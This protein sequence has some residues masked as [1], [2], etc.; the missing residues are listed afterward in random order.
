[1]DGNVQF[2]REAATD[3]LHETLHLQV[4][5]E[6]SDSNWQTNTI[7]TRHSPQPTSGPRLIETR[8]TATAP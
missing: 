4:F 6:R 7:P 3:E 8:A 5:Y 2:E 1:M